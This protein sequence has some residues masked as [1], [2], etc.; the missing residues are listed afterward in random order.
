MTPETDRLV[1][2]LRIM[3]GA[4]FLRGANLFFAVGVVSR[5]NTIP[6]Y[7]LSEKEQVRAGRLVREWQAVTLTEDGA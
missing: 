3:L 1:H 5:A 6:Y 2:N 7:E 4:R